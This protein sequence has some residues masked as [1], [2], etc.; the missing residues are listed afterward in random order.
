[1]EEAINQ[2]GWG[3]V[4]RNAAPQVA[5]ILGLRHQGQ[6]VSQEAGSP[7]F[8]LSFLVKITDVS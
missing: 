1:M 6:A 2:L 3:G 7:P 8:P 5:R 4:V